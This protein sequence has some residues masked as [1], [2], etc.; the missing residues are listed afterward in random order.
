MTHRVSSG[1]V[2]LGV[3]GLGH[4]YAGAPVPALEHVSFEVRAGEV[5]GLLGPNGAGKSTLMSLVAGLLPVQRGRL[6]VQGRSHDP[7]SP[8]QPGMRG[9]VAL[10]PQ[11]D[12]FYP[13]LG[14]RENLACFAATQG[15]SG[16]LAR[17]RIDDALARVQLQAQAGQ[18]AGRLSGGM[19][20][21][22]NLAI[23]LLGRPRLLLLDEP[24]AGVDPQSRAFLLGT[25]AE[26]VAEGA[27]V[28]MS[29]HLI[30]EVESLA[31]RV[32]ILDHGRVQACGPLASLV[33]TS[34]P[35]LALTLDGA[36]AVAHAHVDGPADASLRDLLSGF[37]PT[38]G[39]GADWSVQV[40]DAMAAGRVLIA[41]EQAGHRVRRAQLG[42]PSLEQAFLGL[43]GMR[44][45]DD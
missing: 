44:P 6:L 35:T 37:G 41:L 11:T 22:L 36:H 9:T 25:L 20:R 8:P 14:V 34:T 1:E 16:R 10:A 21:R 40:P 39:Q 15:L 27:A 12:A 38:Q 17:D 43:T 33:T 2:V 7:S 19:R 26:V 4:H 5:T 24:T 13:M 32:V 23:A 18:R 29:S 45:R 28:L 30:G 3:D 31:A 42:T